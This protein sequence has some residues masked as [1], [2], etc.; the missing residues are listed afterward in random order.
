MAKKKKHAKPSDGA[1]GATRSVGSGVGFVF[2]GTEKG[3]I[4]AGYVG[5]VVGK[6]GEITHKSDE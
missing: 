4:E 2:K 3:A 1:P 6:P 5:E